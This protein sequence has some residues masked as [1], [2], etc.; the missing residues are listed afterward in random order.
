[1]D[2]FVAGAKLVLRLTY[3]EADGWELR[4]SSLKTFLQ[5]DIEDAPVNG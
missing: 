4:R 1:V 2:V 3:A 5:W